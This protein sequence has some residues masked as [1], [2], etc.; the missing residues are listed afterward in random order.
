MPEISQG[1]SFRVA[2]PVAAAPGGRVDQGIGRQRDAGAEVVGVDGL[3]GCDV[4]D[5]QRVF[6]GHQQNQQLLWFV[7]CGQGGADRL[8]HVAVFL[9]GDHLVFA[10]RCSV[11]RGQALASEVAEAV[12]TVTSAPGERHATGDLR[13]HLKEWWWDRRPLPGLTTSFLGG[14]ALASIGVDHRQLDLE[15]AGSGVSVLVVTPDPRRH[16]QSP[17]R[18]TWP[19]CPWANHRRSVEDASKVASMPA[20]TGVGLTLK[21]AIGLT[22]DDQKREK[23]DDQQFPQAPL[24]AWG[25]PHCLKKNLKCTF[26][27]ERFA[28]C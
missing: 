26:V 15:S 6:L 24:F 27:I 20:L 13:D 17:K 7:A 1:V 23:A 9:D 5:V 14:V 3:G 25:L 8:G 11:Q 21:L 22:G 16:R 18:K 19:C 2:A 28:Y 12:S 10:H 4:G